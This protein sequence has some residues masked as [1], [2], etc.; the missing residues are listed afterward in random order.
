MR[1]IE[2]R[3]DRFSLNNGN[4]VRFRLVNRKMIDTRFDF[5]TDSPG[6]WDGFWERNAGLGAGGSDPDNASPT[7]QKYHKELWS[8]PLPNGEVMDLRAGSGPYYLT[9]KDFWFGS[10]AITDIFIYK[11]YKHKINQ[12][13]N[14]GKGL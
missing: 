12:V 3:P 5:T 11:K 10:D 7:L 9:L 4:I 6:Y 8:K 14:H 2:S 1:H 13:K